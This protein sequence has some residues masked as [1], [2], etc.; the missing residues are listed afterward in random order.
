MAISTEDQMLAD[1][2]QVYV[3]HHAVLTGKQ[4]L[5]PPHNCV[6]KFNKHA[7]FTT[8]SGGSSMRFKINLFGLILFVSIWLLI[9]CASTKLVSVWKDDAY[10]GGVI[11]SVMVVGVTENHVNRRMFEDKFTERF[12]KWGIDAV[13]SYSVIPTYTGLSRAAVLSEAEKQVISAILATNLL[14][15]KEETIKFEPLDYEPVKSRHYFGSYFPAATQYAHTPVSYKKV[16]SVRLQTNLYERDTEKL[17]W[18]T[19]TETFRPE[20]V[21]EVID[22]LCMEVMQSMRKNGLVK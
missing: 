18:S 11:K 16:E 15:V 10:K 21:K 13:P 3:L 19:V 14:K 7:P 5:Y 12:K 1:K 17:I 20:S 9:A 8:L 6:I 2:D 4:K 22:S